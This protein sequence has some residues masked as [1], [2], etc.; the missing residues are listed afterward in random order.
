MDGDDW[1]EPDT[2]EKLYSYAVKYD[3][4]VVDSDYYQEDELGNT[5]V[6]ISIPNDIVERQNKKELLLNAGRI[7]TKLFKR[8]LLIE[9]NIRFIEHRQFE[10]TPYLPI[11]IPYIK[12]LGKVNAPFYHYIYNPSST[13]RK[14]NDS[15]V[16]DDRLYTS[17]KLLEE[18]KARGIYGKY[19][20]EYDIIFIT[21]YYCVTIVTC[22]RKFSNL[23]FRRI[24]EV[25]SN[26]NRLMPNYRCNEYIISREYYVKVI[27]RLHL[28]GLYI[29]CIL[30]KALMSGNIKRL[31]INQAKKR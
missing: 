7:V 28:P 8:S 22:I 3:C 5:E 12:K 11:L 18:A 14:E 20:N 19:K 17:E 2:L 16:L 26:I 10:D 4:D 9:N 21:I 30:S 24:Y 15:T 27:T 25:Y 31:V 6:R 1:I 13:S 23:P 29:F